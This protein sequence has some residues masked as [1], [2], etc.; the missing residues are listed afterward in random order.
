MPRG[1]TPKARDRLTGSDRMRGTPVYVDGQKVGEIDH[2]MIDSASGS[3]AY[4]VMRCGRDCYPLPWSLLRQREAGDGY[5]A[6]VTRAELE[7]APQYCKDEPWDWT[8]PE[9]AQMLNEYY[10]VAPP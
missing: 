8:R 9:R 4:A 10:N 1:G 3:I 7:G 5:D 2:L 6:E